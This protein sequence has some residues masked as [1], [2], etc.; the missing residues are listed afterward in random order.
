MFE[1]VHHI[2]SSIPCLARKVKKLYGH[3]EATSLYCPNLENNDTRTRINFLDS[4][5]HDK[6]NK[7][8]QTVTQM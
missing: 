6:M 8:A 7:Y 2:E 1:K 4:E 5:N 3:K